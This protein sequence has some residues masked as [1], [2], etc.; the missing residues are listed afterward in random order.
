MIYPIVITLDRYS[1]CYS[2]AT[3]TAWNEDKVPEGADA[4][5]VTCM[6][7]WADMDKQEKLVGKGETPDDAYLNLCIKYKAKEAP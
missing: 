1:G 6:E 4:D 2:G 7:F 5:D 3:F